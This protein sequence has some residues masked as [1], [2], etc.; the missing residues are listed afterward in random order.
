MI[1]YHGSTDIVEKPEIRPISAGRDFGRGFY[2]TDI[3]SQAEKWAR[4]QSQIRKQE[5][6]LNIYEFNADYAQ[7]DL[8][9]KSFKDYSGEWLELV[10]NC[11][12]K[13]DYIHGF[14]K[15]G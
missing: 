7:R 13:A 3:R 11:R 15:L 10:I 4:R 6:V 5:T 8:N 12:K 14:V 1:L 2:C 9:F